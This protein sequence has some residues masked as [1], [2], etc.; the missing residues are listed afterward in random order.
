MFGQV[1]VV[2]GF[3]AGGLRFGAAANAVAAMPCASM[4]DFY[5]GGG[6]DTAC[7][8][9]GEVSTFTESRDGASAA[10]QCL[11][12]QSLSEALQIEGMQPQLRF[13]R[14]NCNSLII[15]AVRT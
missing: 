13:I 10:S 9:M 15:T 11:R 2:G 1:G 12:P 8:G 4:I 7:L 5:Q 14:H 6:A 3:P